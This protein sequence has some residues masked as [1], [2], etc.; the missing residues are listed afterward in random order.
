M[1]RNQI[2]VTPTTIDRF[3]V[4]DTLGA[5]TYGQV[6]LGSYQ[7]NRYAIKRV[8]FGQ[9]M[10]T[11][12]E[13]SLY[14]LMSHP[15]IVSPFEYISSNNHTNIDIVMPEAEGTLNDVISRSPGEIDVRLIAWQLLSTMDYLHSNSIVHRDLKPGNILMDDARAMVIDFGLARFLYQNIDPTSLT[16]QTYTHRAP[17]VF[18]V[19]RRAMNGMPFRDALNNLGT[20]MDMWSIGMMIFEMLL[21]RQ[22]FFSRLRQLTE[23]Q[24]S[25]FLLGLAY[26]GMLVRDINNL[27]ISNEA[28][29][30]I[31]GLLNR[32]PAQRLTAQQAMN[33]PW[34]KEFRYQ[35]PERIQYPIRRVNMQSETTKKI[36]AQVDNLMTRC[37]Y[38]EHVFEQMIRL[39]GEAFF[40]NPSIF[41]NASTRQ[42]YYEILLKIAAAGISEFRSELGRCG[43][44]ENDNPQDIY[45]IFRALRF[46]IIV[47]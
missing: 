21:G 24:V 13:I 19:I 47:Q 1:S 32:N 34:F 25:S 12:W 17:E 36:R 40:N 33:M 11:L 30:V 8:S 42:R 41:S 26:E 23:N 37:S 14:N 20:A 5:G 18:D 15:N 44:T 39:V 9:P 22:Y 38:S 2:P 46:N 45:N 28:K 3:Q 7:G 29:D 4:I 6:Y 27:N 10:Q 31:R 35:P 16:V 43:L